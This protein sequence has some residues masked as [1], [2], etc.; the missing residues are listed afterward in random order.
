MIIAYHFIIYLLLTPQDVV[1]PV[2]YKVIAQ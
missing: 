2:H 1:L